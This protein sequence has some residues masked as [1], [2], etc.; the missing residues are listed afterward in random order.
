[1][2][3]QTPISTLK[4]GRLLE[5]FWRPKVATPN[6]KIMPPANF[7]DDDVPKFV[8]RLNASR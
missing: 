8:A 6:V 1:M 4:T 5:I 7:A 2:A 3:L